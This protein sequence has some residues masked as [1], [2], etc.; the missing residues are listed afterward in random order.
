MLFGSGLSSS[1][2]GQLLSHR[3]ETLE[4][5]EA[6]PQSPQSEKSVQCG[7]ALSS[8]MKTSKELTLEGSRLV[9]NCCIGVF[10]LQV[11]SNA[12]L[13]RVVHTEL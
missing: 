11:N 8:T 1:L 5:K 10:M 12:L 4:D 2:S 6:V 3:D 13:E 9:M 7:V